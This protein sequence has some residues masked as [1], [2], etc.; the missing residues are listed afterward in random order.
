MLRAYKGISKKRTKIY[1]KKFKDLYKINNDKLKLL[2]KDIIKFKSTQKNKKGITIK[3][4]TNKTK[5]TQKH[6]KD[7]D[8][9]KTKK[10]K[11]K[12]TNKDKI[13]A[14]ISQIAYL[15]I[16]QRPL[17]HFNYKYDSFNSSKK[18]V[19]YVNSNN[20]IIGFRGTN[21]TSRRDL[22][23]DLFVA[24]NKME[25]NNYFERCLNRTLEIIENYPNYNIELTGHSLGG[26]ISLFINQMPIIKNKIKGTTVFNPGI[27]ITK[28]NN[29]IIKDYANNKN[30][31]FILKY[32]DPISNGIIQLK[33]KNIVVVVYPLS[34]N[35]LNNHS[36]YNFISNKMKKYIKNIGKV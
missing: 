21:P 4:Q 7:I 31:K 15:N 33:P 18:I 8:I 14:D 35:P 19:V 27:T 1:Y 32:G 20:V 28:Y 30:N 6:Q 12:L 26:A 13:R 25:N 2:D 23:N 9:N 17:K 29:Q 36:L 11:N 34:K 5:K 16:N 24:V 3:N 22:Y 10:Y